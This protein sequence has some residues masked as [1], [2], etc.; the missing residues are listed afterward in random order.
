MK[1]ELHRSEAIW[2]LL[3]QDTILSV[4]V[5]ERDIAQFKR[6][7]QAE[8]MKFL[9]VSLPALGKA[10][11]SAFQSG[12]FECPEGWVRAKN[13]A[14]PAFLK[15]A[16]SEIF[17]PEGRGRWLFTDDSCVTPLYPSEGAP[18]FAARCIRQLTYAFYKY[19]QPWTEDQAQAVTEAFQ[20]AEDEL[21]ATTASLLAGGLHD[22][23]ID[24]IPL[25]V[26]LD[27]AER[28]ISRLLRG[29]SPMDIKP[30]YGTGAT[31]CKSTPWGRWE[32]PRFIPKL[33]AVYSVSDWF[34]SGVN[35]L[36]A[37]M[38][39]SKLELTDCEQPLARV[40]LVPKDSRGPRLI[41]AEPREFMYI[42]QG[43]AKALQAAVESY[44]NVRKQV[45]ITDQERNQWLARYA[46]E[47][48]SLATLDL[49]EASDR[50]SWWLVTKLFPSDWV[51]AF[52]A[53]RSESTVM[54]NGD[55]IPMTKFAPMG[56]ACCFPVEAIVFWALANAVKKDWSESRV[57]ALFDRSKRTW[58]RCQL[59]GLTSLR[60]A[61][62]EITDVSVFGDDIIV[63]VTDVA[64][65]VAVIEA[66]GL[67]VNM[68]KS[69][70]RGPFRES[71]GGDY[72]AG[73]N[74][75]PVRVKSRLLGDNIG[76]LL[77]VKDIFN[78]LSFMYGALNPAFV[79]KLR[80]LFREFF[81]FE[82]AI[83]AVN[84][85]DGT[86]GCL[87]LDY[88]WLQTRDGYTPMQNR[89]GSWSITKVK[90]RRVVKNRLKNDY[91]RTEYRVLTEVADEVTRDLNWCSVL[92]SFHVSGGRGG[93]DVYAFRKRVRYNVAWLT[94]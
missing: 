54:P 74:V 35:G 51:E 90:T 27:R 83:L 63:P 24:G 80:D 28:L 87:L 21:W 85:D 77:R 18:G 67:K 16:W 92:R 3:A 10:L 68:Q 39:N 32:E 76:V 19:E 4:F 12:V 25:Y 78:R 82:I 70:T 89:D 93:A 48:G 23:V 88:H 36:D 56:S 81:G 42:Q 33:D 47:T 79:I 86:T 64:V 55:E 57:K 2:L 71:C 66:V 62:A 15:N 37:R 17:H 52:D 7:L 40:V 11:D 59:P 49:K 43:L 75:T 94:V 58:D 72:Y 34:Y 20:S 44:P 38:R 69:F 6:R 84:H 29:V 14:Y 31:A 9:T 46:S 53:C 30:C 73:Y 1:T 60:S 13:C 91:C 22:V 45:S 50:V 8:G 65:T 41:S 61:Q 5:T 26:Y